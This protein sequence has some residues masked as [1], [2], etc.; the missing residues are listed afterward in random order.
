MKT[1]VL[2]FA[3]TVLA[4]ASAAENYTLTLFQPSVVAGTELKAG[5]YKLTLNDGHVLFKNGRKKFETDVT[6]ETVEEKYKSTRVRYNDNG[7]K[8]HITEIRLGGTNKK[9][10]FN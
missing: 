7:G 3:A 5:D 4:V 10:V 8:L 6:V 9:L 1:I 2:L